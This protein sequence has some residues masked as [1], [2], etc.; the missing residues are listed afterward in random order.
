MFSGV[1]LGSDY[2][3]GLGGGGLFDV[4]LVVV[5]GVGDVVGAAVGVGVEVG[6]GVVVPGGKMPG[7]GGKVLG[8][9]GGNGGK[10]TG[11]KVLGSPKGGT[12]A[13]GGPVTPA[14]GGVGPGVLAGG[15]AGT[16]VLGDVTCAVF[17]GGFTNGSTV[18]SGVVAVAVKRGG[19]GS[20]CFGS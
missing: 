20:D 8:K 5:V 2:R 1:C 10:V 16:G 11:G 7:S 17:R 12:V 4:G 3:P 18:V 19:G 13:V 15:F 6:A 14:S 9:P